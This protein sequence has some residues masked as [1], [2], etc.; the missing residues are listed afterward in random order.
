MNAMAAAKAVG[1]GL[2]D[3]QNIMQSIQT[4]TTANNAKVDRKLY[5][6]NLPSNMK[7]KELVDYVNHAL[8]KVITSKSSGDPVISAWISSDSHYGF[9]E[10]RN[11]DEADLGFA[12]NNISIHGQQLK[13]G[14]PNTYNGAFSSMNLLKSTTLMIGDSMLNP[15]KHAVNVLDAEED[16][17]DPLG[18]KKMLKEENEKKMLKEEG[19]KKPV[20]EEPKIEEEEKSEK[21]DKGKKD[22]REDISNLPL[23][24]MGVLNITT[25]GKMNPLLGGTVNYE[26]HKVELP[27]RILI[28][29]D[30]IKYDYIA[31]EEDYENCMED[32][33]KEMTKHGMIANIKI[34]HYTF[35]QRNDEKEAEEGKVII[36][37]EI[38]LNVIKSKLPSK[39]GFGNVY[40]EF[41]S[42][43][44]AKNARTEL[45]G[46][47]YGKDYV[48]V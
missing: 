25:G 6:G 37:E 39:E 14:R 12:L 28:L 29:K 11:S 19:K 24:K 9:L 22:N 31:Y 47:K 10:F 32:I 3:A 27:S 20:K 42:E 46:R 7:P 48:D 16:L 15:E 5:V 21:S 41:V 23:T 35:L 45:I 44:E 8:K 13:V 4:M 18:D 38:D 43:E 17:F 33:K 40:V 36:E 2:A 34:P 26:I 1:G 30:I